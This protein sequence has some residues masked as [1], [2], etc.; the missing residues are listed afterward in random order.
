MMFF[1][2]IVVVNVDD[3][4]LYDI[5]QGATLTYCFAALAQLQSRCSAVVA[6]IDWVKPKVDQGDDGTMIEGEEVVILESNPAY[7]E[8]I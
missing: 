3:F 4:Q 6:R 2:M 1:R 8:F 5:I 7:S